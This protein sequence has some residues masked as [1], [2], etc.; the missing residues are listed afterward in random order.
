MTS[1]VD[2]GVRHWADVCAEV[3]ARAAAAPSAEEAEAA[4]DALALAQAQATRL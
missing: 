2:A 4:V 3:L 1:A